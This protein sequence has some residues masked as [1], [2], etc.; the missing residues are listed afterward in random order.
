MI[1]ELNDTGVW[2]LLLNSQRPG[3]SIYTGELGQHRFS[4]WLASSIYLNRFLLIANWI[5][6]NTRIE[7]WIKVTIILYLE[8]E[9]ENLVCEMGAIVFR[10]QWVEV[11]E[12][13]FYEHSWEYMTQYSNE[14]KWKYVF[15]QQEGGQGY[16]HEISEFIL[17]FPTK[18]LRD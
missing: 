16:P 9:F 4:K 10:P 3:E 1:S 15:L 5:Q 2:L 7:I 14:D 11:V 13:N 12:Y 18:F 8:I 17:T 6:K